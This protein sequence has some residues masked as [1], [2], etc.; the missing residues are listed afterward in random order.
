MHLATSGLAHHYQRR[1]PERTSL[2]QLVNT[3]L[4]EALAEAAERS[5]HGSG[6]P[7]FIEETFKRDLQCGLLCYGFV[8]VNCSDCGFDRLVA[9]SC[10]TRSL[11]PSCTTRRMHDTAAHLVDRVLPHVPYRQWVMSFPKYL[12]FQLARD[13]TLLTKVLRG[14]LQVI[15]AWQR[16]KA[17]AA[18]VSD[19]RAGAITFVQRFGG[20]VNLNVHY[21]ALVPDG[22]FAKDDAGVPRF[23]QLGPPTDEEVASLAGKIVRRVAKILA[24]HL[25]EQP[26]IDMSDA[27]ARVQAVSIQTNLS[28]RTRPQEQARQ[29]SAFIAGFSLHANVAIHQNDRDGVE[30]LCRYGLR[31]PISLERLSWTA[32]GKIRNEYQRPAPNGA[33]ALECQPVEFLA[34]LAALIPPPRKHL[35]RYHGVFAPNHAWRHQIVPEAPEAAVAPAETN[36]V[37]SSPDVPTPTGAR[38]SATTLAR[39][40]DWA[41]LLMRVFAIDVLECPKCSG[42]MKIL[43]F[44]TEPD[45]VRR[46]LEHLDLPTAPPSSSSRGP[47]RYRACG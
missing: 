43:A 16:R 6:Y 4:S 31:P 9:F 27:L 40:L 20:F 10:K 21:H 45:A 12:R 42:R 19:G 25:E 26:D 7:G 1:E 2:Y 39:R 11:C 23:I 30:R 47:P 24:R 8:R 35:T 28:G 29:R 17:R 34:K 37:N 22:V 14:V 41:A 13:T 18:G 46:I 38:I 32:D 36:E 3:H 33:R 5:E 15:F 44:I